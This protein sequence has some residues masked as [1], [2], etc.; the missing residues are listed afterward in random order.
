M[1]EQPLDAVQRVLQQAL[2]EEYFSPFCTLLLERNMD[3][4]FISPHEDLA[5]FLKE[6]IDECKWLKL[7]DLNSL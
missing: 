2:F 1:A 3:G 5:K 7:V 4:E 6:V